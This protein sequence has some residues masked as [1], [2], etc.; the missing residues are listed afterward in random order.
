MVEGQFAAHVVVDQGLV[1]Q[2]AERV[3]LDLVEGDDLVGGIA[4]E[5][6]DMGRVGFGGGE[7]WQADLVEVVVV[8]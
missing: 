6:K 5:V 8:H 2:G 7:V 1:G 3:G 4:F